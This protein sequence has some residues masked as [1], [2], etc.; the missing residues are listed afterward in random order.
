MATSGELIE[1]VAT[2]LELSPETVG[3][4]MRY[5]RMA[6]LIN[7]RGVGRSAATMFEIDAARM[8][9]ASAGSLQRRTRLRAS[10]ASESFPSRTRPPLRG[11]RGRS[12]LDPIGF[13][14]KSLE[15]NS[16]AA[17]RNIRRSYSDRGFLD[18]VYRDQFVDDDAVEKMGLPALQLLLCS[19]HALPPLRA[20]VVRRFAD[21]E[22]SLFSF[23]RFD[24]EVVDERSFFAAADLPG[25]IQSRWVSPRAGAD[26]AQT[27]QTGNSLG[28][29]RVTDRHAAG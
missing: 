17:L 4:H 23:G 19:R 10:S 29:E 15:L 9:L 1:I 14:R 6:K 24:R 7:R 28:N 20:A 27:A 5:L 21:G 22:V 25:L 16:L 11:R 26:R 8:I 12:P 2:A 13:P 18:L 3:V